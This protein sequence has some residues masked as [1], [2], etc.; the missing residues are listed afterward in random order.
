MLAKQAWRLVNGSNQL[1]T[2]IMKARYYPESDFLNANL[3]NNPSYIWR[4]IIAAQDVMRQGCR[5]RIGNG[6]IRRCGRYLGYPVW[7]MVA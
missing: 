4:S 6:G 7:K 1:V 5:K 3:G 2:N